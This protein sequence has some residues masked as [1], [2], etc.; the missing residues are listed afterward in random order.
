MARLAREENEALKA[1]IQALEAAMGR[2]N[3]AEKPS[4]TANLREKR[5]PDAPD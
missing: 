3:T 5:S 4:E 1:R 2:K